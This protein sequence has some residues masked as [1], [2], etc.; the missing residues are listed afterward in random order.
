[1]S[2]QHHEILAAFSRISSAADLLDHV[3]DACCDNPL[4]RDHVNTVAEAIRCFAQQGAAVAET[5]GQGL[6]NEA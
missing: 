4:L 2:G 5:A 1:M 6:R 3:L